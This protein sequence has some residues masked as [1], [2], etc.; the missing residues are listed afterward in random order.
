MPCLS[1]SK[2]HSD[3]LQPFHR[4]L[5][6]R[7]QW[8][9]LFALELTMLNSREPTFPP[10]G[11][12][13]SDMQESRAGLAWTRS[14]SAVQVP[15]P[16]RPAGLPRRCWWAVPSGRCAPSPG[17]G[18]HVGQ[19]QNGP[20]PRGGRFWPEAFISERL[21]HYIPRKPVH[22]GRSRP[23]KAII[24]F[25]IFPLLSHERPGL[26]SAPGRAARRGEQEPGC[27]APL[28]APTRAVPG[29]PE[30][31]SREVQSQ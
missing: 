15:S 5:R 31:S 25:F 17:A 29:Q 3:F 10:Q 20:G 27:G 2:L 24:S 22:A 12:L 11:R 8:Q 13:R 23:K 19:I 18:G 7:P 21:F 28:P 4:L 26:S 6:P 1:V 14:G 16:F 30:V 9:R